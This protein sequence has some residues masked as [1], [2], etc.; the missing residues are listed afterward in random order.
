M[1]PAAVVSVMS[2]LPEWSNT[3]F[4]IRTKTPTICSDS[5]RLSSKCVENTVRS[6]EDMNPFR[7][8]LG[9]IGSGLVMHSCIYTEK[10]PLDVDPG[11]NACKQ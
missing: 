1:G 11:V 9:A 7:V 5:L 4:V 6:K 3:A 10:C 2:R 8:T